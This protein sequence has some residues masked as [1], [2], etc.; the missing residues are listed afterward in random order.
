MGQA[1][2]KYIDA[3]MD[4]GIRFSGGSDRKKEKK[5]VWSPI[6]I[7]I[8]NQNRIRNLIGFETETILIWPKDPDPVDFTIVN[9]VFFHLKT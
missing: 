1:V 7:Q 4:I 5:K 6:W 2:Y 8:V 9:F 3:G